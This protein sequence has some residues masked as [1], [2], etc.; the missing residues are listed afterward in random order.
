MIEMFT[1][2]K[3]KFYVFLY[4][5]RMMCFQTAESIQD[6][7]VR[8][9]SLPKKNIVWENFL[10]FQKIQKTSAV[11]VLNNLNYLV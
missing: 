9:K 4:S 8:T 11:S 7:S 5:T 2:K 10:V 1:Q 6:K 3:K